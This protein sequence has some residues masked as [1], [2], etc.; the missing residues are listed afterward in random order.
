[1]IEIRST[2][3]SLVLLID[4]SMPNWFKANIPSQARGSTVLDPLGKIIA[5]TTSASPDCPQVHYDMGFDPL[6]IPEGNLHP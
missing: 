1:M 4:I 3:L 6:Y 2:Y 5:D